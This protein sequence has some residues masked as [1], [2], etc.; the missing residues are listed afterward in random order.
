L[1]FFSLTWI[2]FV[3]RALFRKK[4]TVKFQHF[5]FLNLLNQFYHFFS[6]LV[7]FSRTYYFLD[8]FRIFFDI[9]FLYFLIFKII[10]FCGNPK[11]GNNR[12]PLFTMLTNQNIINVL[13]S[14]L[15]K[16]KKKKKQMI[17]LSWATC[18]F[19]RKMVYFQGRP[20]HTLTRSIFMGDLSSNSHWSIFT[21]DLPT[22]VHHGL[23][24]RATYPQIFILVY[25]YGRPALPL[26]LIYFQ[27]RPTHTCSSWSI[28]RGDRPTWSIFIGDLPFYSH[29]S[30]FTGDL[31]T[32]AHPGLFSGATSPHGL[33][34]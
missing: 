25:L 28:F 20:A 3:N 23:F 4:Y 30:I 17:S 34:S 6:I 15:V 2:L 9:F 22:Q 8:F 10:F 16:K 1:D 24:S 12:C 27:G 21:G 18:P 32:H 7:L 33:F 31:P 14:K 13:H 26:T 5:A 11:M 29:W 19:W